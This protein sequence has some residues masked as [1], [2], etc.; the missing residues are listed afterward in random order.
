VDC[1]E[2]RSKLDAYIDDELSR[3][4]SAAMLEHAQKCEDCNTELRYAAMLKGMMADMT[5]EVA[6]PL[7][8]Q[9]AWRKAIRGEARTGNMRRRYKVLGAVAAAF[10]LFIGCAAVLRMQFAPNDGGPAVAADQGGVFTF[11]A[12]DGSDQATRSTVAQDESVGAVTASARLVSSDL[13]VSSETVLGLVGDFGGY[14]GASSVNNNTAYITACVPCEELDTFM[15]SLEYI[16]TV[17]ASRVSGEGDGMASIA[18]TIKA[19]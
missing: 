14:V 8:A 17:D 10:V 4:E 9:A 18:I 2:F 5:K 12:A 15:Q 16:G 1:I 11:V 7:E 6:P 19:K 13:S 3:E